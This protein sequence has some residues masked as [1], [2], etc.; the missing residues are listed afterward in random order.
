MKFTDL[1]KLLE[2]HYGTSRL[3]DI[4]KELDVSPQVV[5]NWKVRNHVPY[6]Y[7]KFVREKNISLDLN[8]DSESKDLE[9]IINELISAFKNHYVFIFGIVS[10]SVFLTVY[11]V[12]FIAQPTF[13]TSAKILPVKSGSSNGMSSIANQ[14]GVSLDSG[15]DQ[16]FFSLKVFPVVIESRDLLSDVLKRKFKTKKYGQEKTLLEILSGGV[17]PVDNTKL[18]IKES[19]AIKKLKKMISVSIAKTTPIVNLSVYSFEAKLVADIASAIINELDKTQKA[20]KLNKSK[21]S[22]SFIKERISQVNI[23]EILKDFRQNNRLINKSPALML[24][25]ERLKREVEVQTQIFIT[26]K[27]KLELLQI[28]LIENSSM[29]KVIEKPEIPIKRTSPKRTKSVIISV[30]VSL[31]ISIFIALNIQNG[32]FALLKSRLVK[33]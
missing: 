30:I 14:F 29:L 26:L 24:E 12:L 15:G 8:K 4:A 25:Q 17:L 9:E 2:R 20:F 13:Y 32:N 18:K 23:E 10:I 28:D 33:I 19:L 22:L 11:Y 7:V 21:E 6:K 5:N 16:L 31:I 27:S 3:A 1:L